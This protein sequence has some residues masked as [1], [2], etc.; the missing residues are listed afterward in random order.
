MRLQNSLRIPVRIETPPTALPEEST[1]AIM[2]ETPPDSKRKTV[3]W[4]LKP[5]T[6]LSG[7]VTQQ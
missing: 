4:R 7:Q 1:H 5:K 3:K 2:M 6:P